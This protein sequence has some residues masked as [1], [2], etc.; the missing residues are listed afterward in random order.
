M[1]L[2][3]KRYL[4][5][6]AFINYFYVSVMSLVL[7]FFKIFFIKTEKKIIFS[8]FSGRSFNDSPRRLFDLIKQDPSFNEYRIIWAFED[9]LSLI[10]V[11]LILSK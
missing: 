11:H 2:I 9:L 3:L 6:I 7:N 5:N 4:Q 10:K 8:S 1:R